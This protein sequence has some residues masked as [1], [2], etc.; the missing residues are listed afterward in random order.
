MISAFAILFGAGLISPLLYRNSLL[1]PLAIIVALFATLFGLFSEPW[2]L[3]GFATNEAVKLFGVVLLVVT[4][5]T[6]LHIED[7]ITITQTLFLSSASIALIHSNNLISFVISFETLSLISIVLVTNFKTEQEAEGAIKI[8]LAGAVATALL[9]LG[10]TLYLI[11]GGSLDNAIGSNLN[12]IQTIGLYIVML[13]IFYKLT[14]VPMHNWAVD[15][16]SKV[17]PQRASLLSAV[18]KTAVAIASFKL[19]YPM[20]IESPHK[21]ILAIAILAIVT[22]TLGNFLALFQKHLSKILA[23]SS[24]AHAGYMLLAFAA[25]ASPYASTGILYMSIAYIFMQSGVFLALWILKSKYNISTL[26]DLKGL[27]SYSP[28]LSLIF[29]IQLFS[30]SG[31]PLLAGFMGKVVVFYAGVDAGLWIFVLIAL[32]NSALSVGY[33][34]WIIKHIYFDKASKE[35]NII[36]NRAYIVGQIILLIGTIYYGIFASEI[37]KVGVVL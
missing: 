5:A 21:V 3:S 34:A 6:L 2:I 20:L 33:Y 7:D 17:L 27:Y 13:A 12:N 31:I 36:L 26:E 9:L 14:I 30:L 11:G 4:V 25:V 1:K 24:I 29:T 18:A 35:Q 8:F 19:F 23:Y 22:M 10:V 32:L 16:Y 28:T 37:F 15:T